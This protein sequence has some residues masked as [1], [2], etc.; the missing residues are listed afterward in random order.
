[1]LKKLFPSLMLLAS[2]TVLYLAFA[3]PSFAATRGKPNIL[4][5]NGDDQVFP[6]LC[7]CPTRIYMGCWC[8]V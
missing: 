7:A 5:L 6:L 4:V 8:I 3:N 1:M 2:V